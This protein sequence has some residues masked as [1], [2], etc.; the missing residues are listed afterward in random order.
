VPDGR[1]VAFVRTNTGASNTFRI[2]SS[3]GE[4][5]SSL[6]AKNFSVLSPSIQLEVIPGI[7]KS[8]ETYF[9]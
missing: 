6:G 3:T 4:K 5:I 7:P 8:V 2:K 1:A 9:P